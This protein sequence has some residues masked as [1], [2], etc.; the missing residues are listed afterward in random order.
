MHFS[1]LNRTPRSQ[2][3]AEFFRF[4]TT[5]FHARGVAFL[6]AEKETRGL[7][8]TPLDKEILQEIVRIVRTKEEVPTCVEVGGKRFAVTYL[9]D[10]S[11]R[12]RDAI[13]SRDANMLSILFGQLASKVKYQLLSTAAPTSR[14]ART[15]TK[16]RATRKTGLKRAQPK[17][18][19]SK[20][21]RQLPQS[22]SSRS[23]ARS[24]ASSARKR[25]LA[26]QKARPKK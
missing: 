24:T 19:S 3:G 13:A 26:T 16:L 9:D 14:V 18:S 12:L 17:G 25:K 20:A 23:K 8:T 1:P 7:T 5:L 2:R 6:G 10:H 4:R 11:Q 21:S 22:A 15:K